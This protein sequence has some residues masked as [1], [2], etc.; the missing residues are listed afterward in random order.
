MNSTNAV[1]DQAINFHST[2]FGDISVSADKVITFSKG[3][4]GFSAL[5]RF[6][7]LDH[8][9][10]GHFKWLQSIDDPAVAFLLTNPAAYRPGY[11]VPLK[12]A[13]LDELS[14][15]DESDMVTLVMVCVSKGDER[16]V[17]LNLKGPVVFN[18]GNM[19]ALQ[20]IVDRDDYSSNH[21]INI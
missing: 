7:L 12:K 4:P 21:V 11:T 3:I 13:E 15:K 1:V 14:L 19:R 8:D 17:S 18:S 2:R 5:R 16:Q 20:S 9:G 6:I 10:E